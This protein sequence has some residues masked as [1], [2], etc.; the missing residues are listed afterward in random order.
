[1]TF[2]VTRLTDKASHKAVVI[3][4]RDNH[5]VNNLKIARRG[6]LVRC[7]IHGVNPIISNVAPTVQ[8]D[9][10]RNSHLTSRARCGAII[11]TGSPDMYDEI[12]GSK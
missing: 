3:T 12:L 11:R 4:G 5:F 9:K 8:T 10:D 6:D 7:P 2:K 1:M